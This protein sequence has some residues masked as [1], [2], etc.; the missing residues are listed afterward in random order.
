MH[1][2]GSKRMLAG[3][4]ETGGEPQHFLGVAWRLWRRAHSG[5]SHKLR[6][7]FG[8]RAGF[9]DDQ[10]VD[11]FERLEGFGVSD[12]DAGA[13]AAAGADHDRHGSGES[14]SAGAGDDEHRDR[15]HQRMRQAG[16]RTDQKP[17]GKSD[18][19]DGHDRGHE[20]GGDAIG[21]ALNGSAAA[22]RLADHLHDSRQQ[23]FGADALGAHDE[24]S[25]RVDGCADHLAAGRF[26]DGNGFAGDHRLVDRTAAFE[27]DAIDGNALSGTDAQAVAGLHLFE[28][29]VFFCNLAGFL[30]NLAS[31]SVHFAGGDEARRFRAEMQQRADGGAGAAAG[32]KFHDLA[33]QDQR[34]DG[35]GRFEVDVG[36]STHAAQRRGKNSWREDRDHAV[37]V[38]DAGAEADQREHVRAAV[39]QRRPETLEEWQAAPEDDGSRQ[40]ELKPGEDRAPRRSD[41][42]IASRDGDSAHEHARPEHAA[43]RNRE[44]WR[45]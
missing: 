11:F 35:G 9:V 29:N 36:I 1:D 21:E 39:D 32:A 37:D 14:E 4:L 10:G 42:M 15:I 16:L 12:Q 23:G 20:P 33:E 6:L 26:F 8:E 45:R 27:H 30:G 41:R 38:G 28:R 40:R 43:H 18:G 25:G 13:G 24:R 34:G 19:R 22:L 17:R 7:A 44:Q 31:F 5:R 2:G 3:A